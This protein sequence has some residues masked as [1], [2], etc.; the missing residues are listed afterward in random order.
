[1]E[2]GAAALPLPVFSVCCVVSAQR[3]MLSELPCLRNF[4]L[5][6]CFMERKIAH[7]R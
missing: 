3:E 1:M 2:V 7:A 4:F 6:F 5:P